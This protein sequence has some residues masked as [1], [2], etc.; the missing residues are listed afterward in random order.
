M[1]RP[2]SGML[3]PGTGPRTAGWGPLFQKTVNTW[4]FPHSARMDLNLWGEGER[5]SS[6]GCYVAF[7]GK[8]LV[9]LWIVNCLGLLC[10]IDG[11]IDSL[12]KYIWNFTFC[13][14]LSGSIKLGLSQRVL[15]YIDGGKI[16]S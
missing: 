9:L 15:F 6:T 12:N 7:I 14:E 16:H 4:F 3:W 11:H 2:I 10:E 8:V 13:E 1:C 5:F